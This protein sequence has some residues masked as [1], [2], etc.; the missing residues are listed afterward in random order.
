MDLIEVRTLVSSD[1]GEEP[2]YFTAQCVNIGFDL[3]KLAWRFV[4]EKE[5]VQRDFVTDSGLRVIDPSV[6][7]MEQNFPSEELLDV[8]LQWNDLGVAQLRIRFG[9]TV[10][11]TTDLRRWI[12]L[13]EGCEH[14]LPLGWKQPHLRGAL[15]FSQGFYE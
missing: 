15:S 14:D 9:V 4:L 7:T 2:D 12:S 10:S 13:A 6:R 11:I 5:A 3:F 8:V 1:F